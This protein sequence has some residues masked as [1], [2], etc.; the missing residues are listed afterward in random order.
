VTDSNGCISDPFIVEIDV[1]APFLP[2]SFVECLSST[3]SILFEWN[4]VPF[5]TGYRVIVGPPLNLN[6]VTTET[7]YLIEGLGEGQ[8]IQ[9]TVVPLG[10]E[11]CGDGPANSITC[12]TEVCPDIS[13]NITQVPFIC[14]NEQAQPITLSVNIV[15]GAGNGTR[16][17][18]GNGI[19]DPSSGIFD[20][21]IA[22]VGR[23]TI[24]LDYQ[25]RLCRYDNSI[26]I[27]VRFVPNGNIQVTSPVC[28][29]QESDIQFIGTAGLNPV[30]DWTIGGGGV[31]QN[32][33]GTPNIDVVW[34]T[35]GT[36][37]ISLN[38]ISEGCA[39]IIP[40]TS[41]EVEQPLQ[42]PAISCN[43]TITSITF[44]WNAI[45]GNQGYEITIN[46]GGPQVIPNNTI[47]F[48][49]MTL[50][51]SI[52]LTVIAL[53]QGP[54]GNSQIDSLWCFAADCPE[55]DVDIVNIDPIC[56]GNNTGSVQLNATVSGGSISGPETYNWT[57][58]GITNRENG[59]FDP[60][61]AGPGR[62]Q[63]F[64]TYRV[65]V[66]PYQTSAFID[67]I[68]SPEL[69][70]SLTD[71]KCFG[72]NDGLISILEID[73]GV[74]PFLFSIDGGS[75]V[76]SDVFSGLR[77][78]SHIVRVRDSNGC[79]NEYSV[80]L[81]QPQPLVVDLGPSLLV[82]QEDVV[83]LHPQLNIP[84]D[85]VVSYLWSGD[86]SLTCLTCDST[87]VI[88]LNQTTISLTVTDVNNCRATDDV[89]I[90]VRLRR[91]VFI[92]NA[93]TPNGDGRNDYFNVYGGVEVSSIKSLKVFDRWGNMVFERLDFK[94]VY[95]T[96]PEDTNGWD[97]TFRG[98]SVRPGV[99]VY[100]AVVEF[101]DGS[102]DDYYGEVT[103]LN[104]E[105]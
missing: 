88:P 33:A 83:T 36:K 5:V 91:R 86:P 7:T 50:G 97:G 30:Y 67:V 65:S 13:L 39:A 16:L 55:M 52:L 1:R 100:H 53:N 104:T 87:Q 46:G 32:G 71:P 98:K 12:E 34:S 49:D 79:T 26:E 40:V 95:R 43:T 48:N 42:N 20:P 74:E 99:F 62:H 21:V 96:D 94:P 11:P 17:W 69:Q 47:S 25:E 85:S 14:L 10:E 37:I 77:P 60:V 93:F 23:H 27:E 35:S 18:S 89:T 51:D 92:P 29:G 58:I 101:L 28:I 72:I 8:S 61:V 80:N 19:V 4:T 3:E 2:V 44:N 105:K 31:I 59:M 24:R 68:Q 54:C 73:G 64:L 78:G 82:D 63:I 70:L 66:C 57:G 84:K 9:I 41:V 90:F 75:F 6:F 103:I 15:G 102:T 45:S 56:L 38:V 76:S 22:G 81:T